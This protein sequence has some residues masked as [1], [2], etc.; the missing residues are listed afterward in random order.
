MI[1]LYIP[2][3]ILLSIKERFANFRN[4]KFKTKIQENFKRLQ[5]ANQRI[6]SVGCES[7]L[8]NLTVQSQV[9]DESMFET[10]GANIMWKR[11]NDQAIK[12]YKV[13]SLKPDKREESG[14]CR[15]LSEG[16]FV[17]PLRSGEFKEGQAEIWQCGGGGQLTHLMFS[18][19]GGRGRGWSTLRC[20]DH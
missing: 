15:S 10:L 3:L 12:L 6:Y 4:Y 19:W 7:K 13:C 20:C 16:E 9:H 11:P 5:T 1:L 2:N 18:C 8:E 14:G 17:S